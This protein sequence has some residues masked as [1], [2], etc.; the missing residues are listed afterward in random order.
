MADNVDY[1]LLVASAAHEQFAR[2]EEPC[3]RCGHKERNHK[4]R[5]CIQCDTSGQHCTRGD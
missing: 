2:D 3:T 1:R 5:T 4:I